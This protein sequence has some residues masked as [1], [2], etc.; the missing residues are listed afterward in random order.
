MSAAR[1]RRICR[2][3]HL[4]A[5]A[6]QRRSVAARGTDPAPRTRGGARNH[7]HRWSFRAG[8]GHPSAGRPC[9][10][11]AGDRSRIDHRSADRRAG[12][13]PNSPILC[14]VC[15]ARATELVAE[16]VFT[17]EIAQAMNMDVGQQESVPC[18]LRIRSG[19][20]VCF[21]RG[22][23]TAEGVGVAVGTGAARASGGPLLVL[24]AAGNSGSD[25]R[26]RSARAVT[27]WPCRALDHLARPCGKWAIPVGC[28][29]ADVA[30]DRRT[31]P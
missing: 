23:L 10:R 17:A 4:R 12:P 25:A 16:A 18:P 8:S 19:V 11:C 9:G 5:A 24:P 27:G 21:R 29:D 7:S 20:P 28:S 1:V 30:R 14:P 22:G 31:S 6:E 2:L 3:K 15:S 26:I 13:Q